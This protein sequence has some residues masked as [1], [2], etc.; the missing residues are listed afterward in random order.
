MGDY[1]HEGSIEQVFKFLDRQ[2]VCTIWGHF[3][4]SRTSS[5]KKVGWQMQSA[6]GPEY[7]IAPLLEK[8][9]LVVEDDK[10][11]V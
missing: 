7:V 4:M 3:V 11:V 1:M 8:L 6:Y 5:I 10:I 2:A 9:H